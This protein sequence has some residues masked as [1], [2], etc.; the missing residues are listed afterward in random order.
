MSE[1][2]NLRWLLDEKLRAD[3]QPIRVLGEGSMATV[4]LARQSSLRRMVAVKVLRPEFAADDIARRRFEREAQS[5]AQLLHSSVP[6]LYGVG[7]L[8]DGVPYIVMEYVD[9]R[10]LADVLMANGP[11]A[12]KEVGRIVG[13]VASALA[14]AHSQGILHRDV[15]PANVLQENFT[16]RIVLTDFGIAALL[17]SASHIVTRLTAL[18]H[19]VGDVRYLSPEQLRGEPLTVQSDVYGLGLFAYE[20][21]T[22]ES[23]FDSSEAPDVI[24]RRSSGKPP[25]LRLSLRGVDREF[26]GLIQRSLSPDPNRRPSAEHIATLLTNTRHS[27]GLRPEQ[28]EPASLAALRDFFNELRRRHVYQFGAAYLAGVFVLLQAADLILRALPTSPSIYNTLV[29][30]S[31]SGFPVVLALSWFY[32]VTRTGVHRTS[33]VPAR[34]NH[35]VGLTGRRLLQVGGLILS[36]VMALGLWLRLRR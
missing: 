18:G 32:D 12:P 16:G 5:A 27:A 1:A 23:L 34:H 9:G 26:Q 10:N 7:R 6:V 4:F 30:A 19:R 8:A 29:A 22:G 24:I 35:P 21:L 13:A 15:R 31:V 28:P 36:V 3:L 14:A 25:R 20:L 17:E 2:I 11:L 33:T